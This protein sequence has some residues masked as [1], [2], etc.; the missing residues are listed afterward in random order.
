M[1]EAL[2]AHLTVI[3]WIGGGIVVAI[4][5]V[6]VVLRDEPPQFHPRD[7]RAVCWEDHYRKAGRKPGRR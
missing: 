3:C 4:G 6:L 2:H 5:Y 1:L 7:S